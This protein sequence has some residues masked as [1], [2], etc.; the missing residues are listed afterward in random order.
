VV[1]AKPLRRAALLATLLGCGA[2]D[3][4]GAGQD[5]PAGYAGPVGRRWAF[6]PAGQ[7]ERPAL[8]IHH[9]GAAWEVRV[10][11]RWRTATPVALWPLSTDGGLF[12]DGIRLLPD[13][14]LTGAA[15]GDVEVLS[16]GEVAVWYGTFDRAV[17][18]EVATVPWHGQHTFVDGFG[19][20]RLGWHAADVGLEG[21]DFELAGYE[22][23]AIE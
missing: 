9:L 17:T 18:A 19:P 5:D 15:D 13:P 4:V 7:P 21:S 14:V 16:V 22:D 2:A 12:V 23:V 11:D 10:G 8:L 6:I 20:I 3:P 1:T